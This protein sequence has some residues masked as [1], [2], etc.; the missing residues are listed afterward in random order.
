MLGIDPKTSYTIRDAE[1]SHSTTGV[2][3]FYAVEIEISHESDFGDHESI[4]FFLAKGSYELWGLGGERDDFKLVF[5]QDLANIYLDSFFQE[6][7]KF[8]EAC[9]RAFPFA[10]VV[11]Q[12]IDESTI[13]TKTREVI[14]DRA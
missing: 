5:T 12:R 3:T 10:L 8:K 6:A 1:V 7:S 14:I 11:V 9:S 2:E 13:V 4:S